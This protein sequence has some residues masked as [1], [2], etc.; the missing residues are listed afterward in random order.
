MYTIPVPEKHNYQIYTSLYRGDQ[1]QLR[2]LV[3][4]S[5]LILFNPKKAISQHSILPREPK[6][7]IADKCHRAI[8]CHRSLILAKHCHYENDSDEILNEPLF[9]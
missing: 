5:G 2:T 6:M 4:I 7:Q 1:W 9:N 8:I 3:E